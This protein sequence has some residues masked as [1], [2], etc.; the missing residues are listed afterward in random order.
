MYQ[1]FDAQTG[2][3]VGWSDSPNLAT[4]SETFGIEWPPLGED[5]E[6]VYWCN[7]MARAKVEVI[8]YKPSSE[9]VYNGADWVLSDAAIATNLASARGAKLTELNAAAQG[10]IDA[11]AKTA[12]VPEF[13]RQSWPLQAPEAKA[14]GADKNADTP[15]LNQMAAS[16]GINP[17]TLKA[18]ALRKTL[19]Y[20]RLVAHVAGQRQALQRR[21][22]QAADVA[23]LEA[24]EISFTP[25]EAA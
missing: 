23:A 2:H 20:E 6:G 12:E 5:D 10:F 15:I 3:W 25:P 24:I 11:A 17:D 14:W 21:I 1:I 8:P 16:R 4:E 9:H 18:A 19:I 13:E 7:P 22:E